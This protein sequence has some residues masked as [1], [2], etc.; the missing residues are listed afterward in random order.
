MNTCVRFEVFCVLFVWE[1]G[2]DIENN[3]LYQSYCMHAYLCRWR[4]LSTAALPWLVPARLGLIRVPC[5]P[6]FLCCTRIP[7]LPC[8]SCCLAW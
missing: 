8:C 4:Y 1:G 6:T 2:V 7:L 3:A 5:K